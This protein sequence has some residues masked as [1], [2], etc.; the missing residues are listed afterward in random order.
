M[1]NRF[2][3]LPSLKEYLQILSTRP[4][5]KANIDTEKLISEDLRIN[6]LANQGS[7]LV[8]VVDFCTK[9]YF[10]LSRN[11]KKI[12]GY[13]RKVFKEGGMEFAIQLQHPEDSEVYAEEV[14][15]RHINFMKSVPSTEKDLCWYTHNCRYKHKD[16]HFMQILLHYRVMQ[17]DNQGNPLVIL[18]YCTDIT[19]HK[20]DNKIV[21]TINKWDEKGG[22]IRISTDYYFPEPEEGTLSKREVEV[23]KWITEGLSSQAIAER[24]NRSIHTVNTHR[25][26]MLEK[27][28]AK[29]MADLIRYAISKG[30]L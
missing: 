17:A 2:N 16:G 10:F 1:S 20:T 29:N 25:K 26:N 3:L 11:F 24:I 4:Q 22:L 9:G 8:F 30:Y 7:D 19:A 23:L 13:D 6:T 21:S 28:N 5:E 18:G 15:K 12:I 27:T 14:F